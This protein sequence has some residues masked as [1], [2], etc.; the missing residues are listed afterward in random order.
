MVALNN[1]FGYQMSTELSEILFIN[2]HFLVQSY[3]DK[4]LKNTLFSHFPHSITP[5]EMVIKS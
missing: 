5:K 4:N 3:A 2:F 1:S